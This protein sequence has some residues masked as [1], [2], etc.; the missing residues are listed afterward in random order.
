M[1]NIGL[2]QQFYTNFADVKYTFQNSTS[3][4]M[5]EILMSKLD[6]TSKSELISGIES[7][8]DTYYVLNM[9]ADVNL[10]VKLSYKTKYVEY[11][12]S[13]LER[14]I[15]D[16]NFDM[17]YQILNIINFN[18]V[19]CFKFNLV[20]DEYNNQLF[21]CLVKLSDSQLIGVSDQLEGKTLNYFCSRK[22][23]LIKYVYSGRYLEGRNLYRYIVYALIKN[24]TIDTIYANDLVTM[25]GLVKYHSEKLSIAFLKWGIHYQIDLIHFLL[26]NNEDEFAHKIYSSLPERAKTSV[27]QECF[28]FY[29]GDYDSNT[30]N[31]YQL[32]TNIDYCCDEKVLIKSL[33]RLN[34][35]KIIELFEKGFYCDKG[36][37]EK[38]LLNIFSVIEIINIFLL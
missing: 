31:Y 38:I 4:L 5:A 14:F 10:A 9:I 12:N 29:S 3:N 1:T 19:I 37:A 27:N 13:R 26:K 11:V 22:P 17:F 6:F 7:R 30:L 16:D 32:R 24:E 21:N 20:S 8:C 18:E 35:D 33:A 15:Q 2:S 25:K 34:T 23:L 28:A 36:K